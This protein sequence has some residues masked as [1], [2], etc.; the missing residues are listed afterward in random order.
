MREI[1]GLEAGALRRRQ[2]AAL[3]RLLRR[4][5]RC[6]QDTTRAGRER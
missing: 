3:A 2:V 4:A 6:H 1:H 5:A